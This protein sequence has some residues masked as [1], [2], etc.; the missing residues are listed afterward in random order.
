MWSRFISIVQGGQSLTASSERR[1]LNPG[2]IQAL[3]DYAALRLSAEQMRFALREAMTVRVDGPKRSLEFYF[4]NSTPDVLITRQDIE[5]ALEKRRAQL[6]TEDELSEWASML[7]LN[8]AY[9]F[10]P[11]DEALIVAW[12]N[13]LSYGLT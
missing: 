13:D 7:L 2:E 6:I 4:D 9:G 11:K 10:D 8:D 12:L 1:R 3:K 5:R